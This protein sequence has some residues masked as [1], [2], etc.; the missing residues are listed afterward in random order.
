MTPA[1]RLLAFVGV[2]AVVFALAFAAG[3]A[4]ESG[5]GDGRA[6]PAERPASHGTGEAGGHAQP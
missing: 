3:A 2:L 6:A 4:I 5:G 1:V